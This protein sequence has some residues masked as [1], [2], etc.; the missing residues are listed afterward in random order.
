MNKTKNYGFNLPEKNE[1]YNV[2]L[3]NENTELFDKKLKEVADGAG[4]ANTVN[5]FTV[6]KSLSELGL[7]EATATPEAIV[8]A[9]QNDS[10]LIHACGASATTSL[11]A[12]P[13]NYGLLQV[14]KRSTSYADFV[15]SMMDHRY[16][17]YYNG[18]SSRKWGGWTTQ[19]LPLT[20]GNLSNTVRIIREDETDIMFRLANSLHAG[21]FAV[22][23]NGNFGLYDSTHSKWVV[24]VG[25]SGQMYI[26]GGKTPIHTGNMASHVLPLT[27]GTLTGD[28]K[29]KKSGYPTETRIIN[30][31]GAT[32][33]RDYTDENN[34]TDLSITQAGNLLHKHKRD[35]KITENTVLHTGNSAPVVIQETAPSDTTALWVW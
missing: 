24:Q 17:G 28:L 10:M 31:N 4:D 9:M 15:Y 23:S 12:L 22:T 27:G 19:F 1:F 34:Y 20:G 5:G 16:Y 26:D 30:Y 7:S 33:I 25:S 8:T 2:E 6:Y 21:H 14:L 18:G 3:V 13:I 32:F 29:F 35:G 11:L